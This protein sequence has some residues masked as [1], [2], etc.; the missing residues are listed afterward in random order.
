VHPDA[1]SAVIVDGLFWFKRIR[2]AAYRVVM[3]QVEAKE[4]TAG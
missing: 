3:R 2:L 4:Q 1:A